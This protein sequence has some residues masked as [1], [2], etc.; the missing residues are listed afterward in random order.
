MA[1]D[2][3]SFTERER[4]FLRRMA[5][6]YPVDQPQPIA[7]GRSW[8]IALVVLAALTAT[9]R[10]VSQEWLAWPIPILLGLIGFLQYKRFTRFKN[11]LLAKAGHPFVEQ[12]A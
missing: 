8:L 10:L 11:R 1:D 9:A 4:R 6:K 2:P 7:T 3:W 12:D 5:M